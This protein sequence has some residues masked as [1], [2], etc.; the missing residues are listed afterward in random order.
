MDKEMPT[1]MQYLDVTKLSPN[2]I[3]GKT[4][5]NRFEKMDPAE[6]PLGDFKPGNVPTS[7]FNER[8]H[9]FKTE[10]SA[11]SISRRIMPLIDGVTNAK[12]DV[13]YVNYEVQDSLDMI[14]LRDKGAIMMDSNYQDVEPIM[15]DIFRDI[16]TEKNAKSKPKGPVGVINSKQTVRNFYEYVSARTQKH[17]LCMKILSEKEL[18]LIFH[19]DMDMIYGIF[20]RGIYRD[21]CEEYGDGNNKSR[22][23]SEEES[24][25]RLRREDKLRLCQLEGQT[26][27]ISDIKEEKGLLNL[28]SQCEFEPKLYGYCYRDKELMGH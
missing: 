16:N 13:K 6:I 24:M 11:V 20:T 10:M 12:T 25:G 8:L 27:M 9:N 4:G 2:K 18:V 26:I 7:V 23:L 17:V 28:L 22:K 19:M 21:I 3:H 15:M 1:P 5:N 14:E